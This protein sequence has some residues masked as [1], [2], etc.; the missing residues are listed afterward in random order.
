VSL[1]DW[2]LALHVLSAFAYVAGIVLFWILVVAI[3]QIDT[4]EGT[5]RLWP[6]VKVGNASVGIG[7]GGTIILGIWL[8]FS[9]GGYDVWDGWI[10][11]AIVLWLISAE[12]GRRTGGAYMQGLGKA[13]EL[14]AAGQ[15]GP[16]S[17]LL[18]LNRTSTGVLLHT[19]TSVVVLL[20]LI[21]MIWKPGALSVLAAVRP[22][23]WNFPLFLHV[24]GAM[25]LVGGLVA[26]ASALAFARGEARLLRLGY[27]S[28]LAVSLPGWV[29]MR[30]GAQWIYS[31]EGW[32]DV[33]DKFRPGWLDIGVIIGDLGGLI[34]L[35]SLL[36]GGVGVYRLREGKG[37]GLLKVTLVL[38]L[39]LLA[40]YVVAV[41]AMAGKPD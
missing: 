28:L 39:V 14:R 1:D 2:I 29:L 17:E 11:A 13:Q 24:L 21:D 3:R 19:L 15:T 34:L 6:V 35:V 7:A 38:S 4:P 12:L 8:A 40:A 25:I 41:W 16:S 37:S 18:A 9:A 23:S 36:A 10:V 31:K 22:D 20:I 26:G 5:I 27:W 30:I 33:P 32:D